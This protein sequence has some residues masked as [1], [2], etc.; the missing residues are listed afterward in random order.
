MGGSGVAAGD[1]G[2]AEGKGGEGEEKKEEECGEVAD[3]PAAVVI[4]YRGIGVLVGKRRGRGRGVDEIGCGWE[5]E[6]LGRG[7]EGVL[8]HGRLGFV[9]A[10]HRAGGGGGGGGGGRCRPGSGGAKSERSGL[11]RK[12]DGGGK[13]NDQNEH[14]WG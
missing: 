13:R 5:K 6:G 12:G 10:A 3:R 9:T 14:A 11:Q 7:G 4:G 1:G 2:D 8:S